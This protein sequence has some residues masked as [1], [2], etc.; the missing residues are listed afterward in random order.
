MC[1]LCGLFGTADHWS[2]AL[3]GGGLTATAE[4]HHRTAVANRVLGPYSLRLAEWSGRYV[5][6]SRTGKGAVVE[7][8][9]ALWPAAE[10]LAGRPLDPLDPAALAALERAG[11]GR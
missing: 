5:L 9:G 11:E 3:A 2:D 10:R 1:G 8:L 6:T 7:G 4:R